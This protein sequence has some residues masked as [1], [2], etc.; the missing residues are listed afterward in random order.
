MWW[1][2]ASRT[3]TKR[4]CVKRDKI[5]C[6]EYDSYS[7]VKSQHNWGGTCVAKNKH[8]NIHFNDK[9]GIQMSYETYKESIYNL[10]LNLLTISY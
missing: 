10:D 9:Q 6:P 3:D 2:V 7:K 8:T 1:G 5:V 4:T